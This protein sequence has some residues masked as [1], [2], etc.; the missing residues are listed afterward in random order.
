MKYFLLIA[1]LLIL[2][3]TLFA[4]QDDLSKSKGTT[5][6]VIVQL[7]PSPAQEDV[8]RYT[9]I[10]ASFNVPLD[11]KHVKKFDVK[12]K[13]LS[14]KEKNDIKGT[15]GY[16]EAEKKVTF[17]PAESLTPGVYEVEFKSLKADKTHKDVKIK[18]IKYRFVVPTLVSLTLETNTTSLNLG[19]KAQLGVTA[20]YDNN[21]VKDVTDKVEWI[22]NPAD[23][24]Q[25]GGNLLTALK[26]TDVTVQAKMETILSNTLDLEI[27]WEVDGHRLP[28]EPD[29]AVNNATLLGIDVNNNNVRDDV[30]RWIYNRYKGDHPIMIPLKLQEARAFRYIIQDPS[31]A[32]DRRKKGVDALNCADA[33]GAWANAFGRKPLFN[34]ESE[35]VI[36]EVRERENIQFNTAQRARAYGEYN[37][38]LSGGVYESEW[39][40]EK[41]I[42]NCDF[43]TTKY[44][45]M[46]EK[47]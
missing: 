15:V 5:Q 28:P 4:S 9:K 7:M 11:A 30:E 12:L 13:C 46:S 6:D 47:L 41:W 37:Q 42:E 23:T 19:E 18:E 21:V 35:V 34:K 45:E 26:D 31:Q 1:S 22:I 40:S 24:V 44:I 2:P 20:T 32:R 3:F 10:E 25:I 27:Y 33:F 17:T 8:S 38:N 14:C 16:V 43:N 36:K 39:P 29:P